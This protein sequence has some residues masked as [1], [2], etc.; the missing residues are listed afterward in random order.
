MSIYDKA[1]ELAR[2]LNT[3]A[4]YQ[5]LVG[6]KKVLEQDSKAQE[7]VRD[8]LA[9]QMA[10]EYERM[11]GQPST[12]KEADLQKFMEVLMLNQTAAQFLQA[13]FKF[14]R[15]MADIYKVLGDSIAEGMDIFG[16]LPR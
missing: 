5:A 12:E 3:S 7:L 14:Q 16:K 10:Y 15:L 1:H 6:A 13:H 2:L 8:F 4:E 11:T 9:K